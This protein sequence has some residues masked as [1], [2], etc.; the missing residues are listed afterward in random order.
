MSADLQTWTEVPIP[1]A[2]GIGG[3]ASFGGRTVL[4]TGGPV[5]EMG[6]GETIAWISEAAPEATAVAP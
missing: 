6:L 2:A 4:V 1:Q 3:L 5:P